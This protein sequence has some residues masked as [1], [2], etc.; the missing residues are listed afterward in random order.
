M[1]TSRVLAE[2]DMLRAS[3][4][5]LEYQPVGGWVRLP[6]YQVDDT[7]WALA[8]VEAC[9]QVP[10]NYPGQA[11]YA[12]YVRPDLKLADGR[13]PNNYQFPVATGL[14]DG[15]GKFS[16]LVDPWVPADVPTAGSNLLNFVRSFSERLKEGF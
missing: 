5:D 15:W 6:R 13:T 12:I 14:G 4:P 2:V 3:W 9:F 11:P 10:E 8:R 7:Q 16:W 1:D